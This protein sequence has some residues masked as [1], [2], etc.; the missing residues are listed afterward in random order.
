[1]PKK[2]IRVAFCMRDMQMGGAEAVL[3]RTLEQLIKRDDLDVSFV[4]YVKITEPVY[5]Q[6][7]ANH[8]Q[9]K[10]YVLYPQ[11]RK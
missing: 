4:S 6:W 9:V 5:A 8:P 3:V 7:F 11:P 2:K 1:M 10:Q